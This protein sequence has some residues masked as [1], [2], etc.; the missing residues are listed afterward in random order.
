MKWARRDS[1]LKRDLMRPAGELCVAEGTGEIVFAS[2]KIL[3]VLSSFHK[4]IERLLLG[5]QD[6][7]KIL[8]ASTI[9]DTMTVKNIRETE[10][11]VLK[12]EELEKKLKA[13]FEDVTRR[14]EELQT[15]MM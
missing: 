4:Q 3:Q 7:L 14:I 5:E 13:L 15:G 10:A 1:G 11:S 2:R 8:R 6:Y 12:H 9:S